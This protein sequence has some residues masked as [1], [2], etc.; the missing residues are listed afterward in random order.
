MRKGFVSVLLLLRNFRGIGGSLVGRARLRLDLIIRP[1]QLDALRE[2]S[3]AAFEREMADHLWQFSPIHCQVIKE[4]G[5]YEVIRLG[6]KRSADCGFANRGSI[7]LFLELMFMFGS[8]FSTD[9]QHAWAEPYLDPSM[10]ADEMYRAELLFNA[11]Q[12]Y[13]ERVSGPNHR[14]AAASLRRTRAE[15]SQAG[16]RLA[17]PPDEFEPAIL[18]TLRAVYP[19]KAAYL[20]DEGLRRIVAIG[21]QLAAQHDIRHMRGTAVFV[22]LVF[23]LGH[24]FAND[25]LYPWL[26][27]VLVD[28]L[29]ATPEDRAARLEAKAVIYLDRV[30]EYVRDL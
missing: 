4:S 12:N 13:L 22:F 10:P 8:E 21:G 17:I 26:R 11:A 3:L 25:P 5:V 20:K 6:M 14:Y 7:R 16:Q 29:L 19:E 23:A 9:P 30:I 18:S 24:G 2:A 28:P 1:N 27:N 15:I